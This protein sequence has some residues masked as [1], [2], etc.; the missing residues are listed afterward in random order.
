RDLD[1][2]PPTDVRSLMLVEAQGAGAYFGG[3][4]DVPVR[5]KGTAKRPIP[6]EWQ[7]MPLRS[8]LFGGRNRHASHPVMAM[9]NYAYGVLESQVRA[10]AFA[11]GLA[12][13]IGS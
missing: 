9:V 5:W 2:E 7:R 6:P 8:S 1:A 12:P 13:T 10:A 4:L 3:W 11:R